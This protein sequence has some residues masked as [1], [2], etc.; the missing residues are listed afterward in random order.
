MALSPSHCNC[1]LPA[2]A[3]FLLTPFAEG[4]TMT[5]IKL[6]AIVLLVAGVLALAYGGFSY[7]KETHEAKLGP[8]EMSVNEKQHVN[9]PMWAGLAAVGAGAAMLF[10][11]V[12]S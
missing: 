6:F 9:I 11:P 7:T 8:I 1:E 3:C 12:K 5:P 10:M 2:A 4:E